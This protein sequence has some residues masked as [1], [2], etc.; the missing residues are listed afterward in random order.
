M[1]KIL[2]RVSLDRMIFEEGVKFKARRNAE[3]S[4]KL[5]RGNS[6]L[7]ESFERHGLQC[8]ARRIVVRQLERSGQIIGNCNGDLHALS[9]TEFGFS[10]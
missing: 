2:G 9:I 6:P 10:I 4:A 3:K 8:R 1:F 5:V 7:P